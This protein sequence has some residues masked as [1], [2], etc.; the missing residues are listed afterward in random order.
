M[1]IDR[2]SLQ[3]SS[4]LQSK[5]KMKVAVNL[6]FL[7]LAIAFSML[8]LLWLY[9]GNVVN[10]VGSWMTSSYT[11]RFAS[12]KREILRRLEKSEILAAVELLEEKKWR[13][14]RLSDRAFPLKRQILQALMYQLHRTKRYEELLHWSGIWI[15]EDE[16]NV[17][18]MAYWYEALRHSH[19]RHDEGL[20]GLKREWHRFPANN[21][22]ESFNLMMSYEKQGY[23][24][25]SSAMTIGAKRYLSSA[26]DPDWF[27]SNTQGWELRWHW[28]IRHVIASYMR[29]QKQR[30][31]D[32]EWGEL[33]NAPQELWRT[34]LDWKN[35]EQLNTKG[36]LQLSVFPD[37]DDRIHIRAEIPRNMSTIRID[38]P[39]HI[40]M[41]ISEL[42]LTIDGE[43][44]H[45]ARDDI[46][47][48][49][50]VENEGSIESDGHWDPFFQINLLGVDK[51]GEKPLLVV[52]ISFRATSLGDFGKETL[53]SNKLATD[54]GF[55]KESSKQ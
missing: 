40:K 25:L 9:Q 16:R 44:K 1:R 4:I 37:L 34:L 23:K 30:L 53:L 45:I 33:W 24:S 20:Q 5:K 41:R 35:K 18:A 22:L 15:A 31:T 2:F 51:A 52:D 13:E 36:Y 19:D 29:H 17:N 39:P 43:S 21:L 32:G 50:F 3:L 54:L 38:L 11:N 46:E 55:K 12:E 47:Y 27:R 14:I 7:V 48:E 6:V 26:Q 49:H 8:W 42:G 10:D 28:K